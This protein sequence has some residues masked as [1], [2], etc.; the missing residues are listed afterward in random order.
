MSHMSHYNKKIRAHTLILA[1][2]CLALYQFFLLIKTKWCIKCES[3]FGNPTSI[4]YICV[5]CWFWISHMSGMFSSLCFGFDWV[6]K[7]GAVLYGNL[8]NIFQFLNNITHIFTHFFTH[9]YFQKIQTTL[10][11]QCYQ[12]ATYLSWFAFI[13]L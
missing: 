9:T 8:S 12:T 10:L 5:K 2:A 1:L 11:K 4:E 13:I 6:S 3:Q 7:L